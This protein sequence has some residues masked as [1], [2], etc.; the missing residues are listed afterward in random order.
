MTHLTGHFCKNIE[1]LLQPGMTLANYETVWELDHIKPLKGKK[2]P[3]DM[4]TL[5]GCLLAHHWSN[6]QPELSSRNA[7]K[8]N[9]ERYRLCPTCNQRWY[10]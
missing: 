1:S 8:G 5:K 4:K 2:S 3:F 7:S 6:W 9:R 10:Y